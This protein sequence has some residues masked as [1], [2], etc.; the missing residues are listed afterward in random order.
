MLCTTHLL[1][2][3]IPASVPIHSIR[4]HIAKYINPPFHFAGITGTSQL[5]DS[6]NSYGCI[7]TLQSSSPSVSPEISCDTIVIDN[8]YIPIT[9][10]S[11]PEPFRLQDNTLVVTGLD[12]SS[13]DSVIT[14][15]SKF[16]RITFFTKINDGRKCFLLLFTL[17]YFVIFVELFRDSLLFFSKQCT[18]SA[19]GDRTN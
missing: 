4:D 14:F 1:L 18:S 16:G 8:Q 3:N 15:F 2:S 19:A 5:D 11:K 13:A 6:K 10:Y 9:Y 17:F 12:Y 7:L